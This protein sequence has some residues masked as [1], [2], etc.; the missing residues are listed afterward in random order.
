QN[1]NDIIISIEKSNLTIDIQE[2]LPIINNYTKQDKQSLD[3]YNIFIAFYG[4][5]LNGSKEIESNPL[6]FGELDNDGV[7]NESKPIYFLQGNEDL[8]SADSNT[9]NCHA[10][11]SARNDKNI[12]TSTLQIFLHSSTL[13][14]LHYSL[15]HS[16]LHI[17]LKCNSS[18]SKEIEDKEKTLLESKA[19]DSKENK[20]SISTAF[21]CPV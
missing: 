10:D 14:I 13:T 21:L 20:E 15:I 2:L 7:F 9:M 5:I 1:D 18:E 19:K 8:S 11:K 12:G 4:T 6:F 16:S 3:E 17:K